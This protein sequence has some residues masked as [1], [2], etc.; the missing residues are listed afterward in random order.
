[1]KV[2][3][4]VRPSWDSVGTMLGIITEGPFSLNPDDTSALDDTSVV[5]VRW[6][7][8]G[9]QDA[10]DSSYS[11]RYLKKVASAAG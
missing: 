3:D 10:E 6:Q 5:I 11:C 2:G 7:G 8:W 9:K 1:M 4:L